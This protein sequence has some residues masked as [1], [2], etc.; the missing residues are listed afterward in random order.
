MT[1]EQWLN[2]AADILREYYGVNHAFGRQL[3]YLVLY[4]YDAGVDFDITSAWRDPGHQKDLQRAWD[5]GDRKG[6]AA[7]PA[8]QSKHCHT[9]ISGRPDAMA[10]DLACGPR[11]K[12]V[13]KFAK[14]CG[15]KWGGDFVTS[16]DPVHFYV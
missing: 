14:F 5:R 8:D 9:D 11:L 6:L 1:L 10:V 15:I 7:R 13:V 3:A 2:Y 16:P 4:C 12:E